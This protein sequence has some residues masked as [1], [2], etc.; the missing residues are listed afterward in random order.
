[1]SSINKFRIRRR[2]SRSAPPLPP[3][4]ASQPMDE[5]HSRPVATVC[6]RRRSRL[7]GHSPTGVLPMGRGDQHRWEAAAWVNHLQGQHE[8]VLFVANCLRCVISCEKPAPYWAR[9]A[10]RMTS[11]FGSCDCTPRRRRHR[12]RLLTGIAATGTKPLLGR[13]C[14]GAL[15]PPHT[16]AQ[17]ML[18]DCYWCLLRPWQPLGGED[19]PSLLMLWTMM[20]SAPSEAEVLTDDY[21]AKGEGFAGRRMSMAG[22]RR[23]P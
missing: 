15:G 18:R 20:T 7:P 19:D 2:R 9:V 10:T 3:P 22:D 6:R 1:M 5:R 4:A 12:A 17:Q 16:Q 23:E 13:N 21:E 11:A 14:Y 8:R